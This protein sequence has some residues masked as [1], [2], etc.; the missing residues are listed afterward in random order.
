MRKRVHKLSIL[1]LLAEHFKRGKIIIE[2]IKHNT[3]KQNSLTIVSVAI[4]VALLQLSHVIFTCFCRITAAVF[5]QIWF[6]VARTRLQCL[7]F[8][9]YTLLL[10]L[11]IYFVCKQLF[12]FVPLLYYSNRIIYISLFGYRRKLKS[13]S[14]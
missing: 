6:Y 14:F 11:Y 13:C 10:L 7:L 2:M 3:I 8:I 1:L 5:T 12:F 4:I 9:F